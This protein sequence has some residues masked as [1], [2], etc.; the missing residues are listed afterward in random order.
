MPATLEGEFLSSS[1]T[2][3]SLPDIIKVG[4]NGWGRIG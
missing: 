4:I 3:T 1:D 2:M